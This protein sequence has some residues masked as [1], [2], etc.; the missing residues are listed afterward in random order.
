MLDDC[1]SQSA[2]AG[3]GVEETLRRAFTAH[4]KGSQSAFAGYGLKSEE[5]NYEHPGFIVSQSAFAGY[6]LKRKMA[7]KSHIYSM[8][9]RNPL[10]LDMGWKHLYWLYVQRRGPVAIRFRWI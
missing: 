2:F 7:A 1:R 5:E 6:G 3:Y 10:S 8:E 9:S 4:Q